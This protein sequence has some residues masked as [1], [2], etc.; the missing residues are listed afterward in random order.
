MGMGMTWEAQGCMGV[1]QG[2][3]L[4][5]SSVQATYPGRYLGMYKYLTYL[6]RVYKQEAPSGRL[7]T[8]GPTAGGLMVLTYL[9]PYS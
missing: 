1:E 8:K 3:P 2:A 5:S 7:G 9:K 4:A 6:S